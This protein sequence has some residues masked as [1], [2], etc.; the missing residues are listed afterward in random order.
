MMYIVMLRRYE[1]G[2]QSSLVGLGVDNE[3]AQL[4]AL[5]ETC[6]NELRK[7]EKRNQE[8]L[9][10]KE[11]E[12]QRWTTSW[13]I[14]NG[15]IDTQGNRLSGSGFFRKA[16]VLG[17][18]SE[19]QQPAQ[20]QEV[21][22]HMSEGAPAWPVLMLYPQYGQLD[23]IQGAAEEDMLAEHMA[24]MFP[25]IEKPQKGAGNPA[26]PWDRDCEYQVSK[27]VVYA[28]LEAAPRIKTLNEWIHSCR[29]Q[30][31]LRGEY[32]SDISEKVL[33]V[34]RKRSQVHEKTLTNAAER[35][36]PMTKRK[37]SDKPSPVD[38]SNTPLSRV[39]YL[40][41]H[42]G[43]K[44]QDILLAPNHVLSGGLLTLLVYVKESDA[45]E[46]FLSDVRKNGQ[47]IWTLNPAG[48]KPTER[49]L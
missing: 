27:L 1:E 43:C 13:E 21:I 22:P 26:V 12:E 25:V 39:G 30:S 10:R 28:P 38:T 46:K 32:G 49:I 9:R 33:S 35:Q 36:A 17:Y 34:V 24:Q 8:L 23:V 44:L 15:T 47:G 7:I 20:L 40:E 5:K 2:L 4:R 37:A 3:N 41:V 42:M 45:Q 14:A 31:A 16:V 6:E 11:A 19:S 29:E 18:A 48:T